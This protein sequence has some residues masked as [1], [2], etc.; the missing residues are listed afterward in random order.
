MKRF[1]PQDRSSADGEF[2]RRFNRQDAKTPRQQLQFIRTIRSLPFFLNVDPK[3]KSGRGG[4]PDRRSPNRVR[5]C[6][7]LPWPLGPLAVCLDYVLK[8]GEPYRELGEGHFDGIDRERSKNRLVER[9]KKLGYSVEIT[10]VSEPSAVG[11]F[12]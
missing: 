6:R 2:L 8:T 11:S 12:S 9:T 5:P 10:G 1:V 7:F 3:F 4:V